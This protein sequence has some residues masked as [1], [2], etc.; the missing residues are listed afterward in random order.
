MTLVKNKKIRFTKPAKIFLILFFS[1]YLLGLGYLSIELL[2][3]SIG[4]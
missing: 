1:A 3:I 2:D 4:L